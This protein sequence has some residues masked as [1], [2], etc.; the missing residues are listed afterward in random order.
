MKKIIFSSVLILAL[1]LLPIGLGGC[2]NNNKALSANEFY[3]MGL[4]TGANYLNALKSQNPTSLTTIET[5]HKTVIENYVDMF[6]GLMDKGIHPTISTPTTDDGVNSSYQKKMTINLSQVTYTLF[7]NQVDLG[8]TTEKDESETKTL[9]EGIAI[10][11]NNTYY[12]KGG[13][14]VETEIE[15]GKT[16][17][18]TELIMIISDKTINITDNEIKTATPQND[19]N[20]IILEEEFEEEEYEYSYTTSQDPSNPVSI[21]F[22]NEKGKE[23]LEVEIG[24]IEYKITK[25]SDSKYKIVKIENNK[26]SVFYME[27]Q[28][29]EYIYTNKDGQTV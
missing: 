21:E 14:N 29:Q 1:I 15:Q 10:S 12:V 20:Y 18:E 9:I 3:A 6:G 16:E 24:T 5:G 11:G 22:E 26:K 25:T 28:S 13:R 8:T 27:Q 17:V 7:Y 4:T 2:K 19:S 23:E